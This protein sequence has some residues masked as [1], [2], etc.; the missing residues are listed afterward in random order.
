MTCINADT[1]RTDRYEKPRRTGWI[2]FLPMAIGII[3][4]PLRAQDAAPVESEDPLPV[5]EDSP[6]KT[7]TRPL[8]NAPDLPPKTDNPAPQAQEDKQRLEQILAVLEKE[9]A[10]ETLL[11]A[12]LKLADA[13]VEGARSWYRRARLSPLL[14]SIKISVGYDLEHDESLDRTQLDP[15]EWGA[16]TDRDLEMEATA[17]WDFSN[18]IYHPEELKIQTALAKRSD[19]REAL[20]TLLIGY[21]FE[22]RQLQIML[23]FRPPQHLEEHIQHTLRVKELTACIDALTG[24][25]LTR[26]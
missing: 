19:R 2:F 10:L 18:L 17:Q 1:T 21:W 25:R 13:D 3:A 24:G 26:K 16:D 23:A 12:A 22:R 4:M 14:P 15:D 11:Q 20:S 6:A 5:T 7:E 9:P 8:P